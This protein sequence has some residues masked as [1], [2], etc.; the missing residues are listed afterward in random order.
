M[1][2]NM[3]KANCFFMDDGGKVERG[4][5]RKNSLAKHIAPL[6]KLHTNYKLTIRNFRLYLMRFKL[7]LLLV[8]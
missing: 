6:S 1:G 3:F 2:W 5:A 4:F 8:Q 7:D